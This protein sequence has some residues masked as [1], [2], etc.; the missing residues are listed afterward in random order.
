MEARL[1]CFALK[2]LIAQI[3]GRRSPQRLQRHMDIVKLASRH[4]KERKSTTRLESNSHEGGPANRIDHKEARMYPAEYTSAQILKL[5]L[6]LRVIYPQSI[7]T[8][9]DNQLY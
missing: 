6:M 7:R 4:G 2:Q 9:I 3:A 5:I 8:Q 1:H